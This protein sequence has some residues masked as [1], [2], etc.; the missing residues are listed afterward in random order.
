MG[1]RLS[2]LLLVLDNLLVRSRDKLSLVLLLSLAHEA[3][4]TELI[5]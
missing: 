4:H 3:G 1:E 2:G 5:Q